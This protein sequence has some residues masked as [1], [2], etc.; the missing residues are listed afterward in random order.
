MG[1]SSTVCTKVPQPVL[2]RIL[3]FLALAAEVVV[4]VCLVQG[5]VSATLRDAHTALGLQ[6]QRSS[7]SSIRLSAGRVHTELQ[8]VGGLEPAMQQRVEEPQAVNPSRTAVPQN[9]F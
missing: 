3:F 2:H 8:Q 5:H 4:T 6:G 9:K 7:E 1:T